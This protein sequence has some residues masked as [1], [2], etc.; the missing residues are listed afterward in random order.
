MAKKNKRDFQKTRNHLANWA[1]QNKRNAAG[2]HGD[3]RKEK[4]R[5]ACRG[6]YQ[7]DD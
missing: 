4:S 7:G 6:R 5:K 2:S 3:A 1:W